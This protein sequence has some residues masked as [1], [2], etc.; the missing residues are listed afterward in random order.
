M[1]WTKASA[2]KLKHKP[3]HKRTRHHLAWAT[4]TFSDHRPFAFSFS[5]NGYFHYMA[6][7]LFVGLFEWWAAEPPCLSTQTRIATPGISAVGPRCIH[8]SAATA[9]V[10]KTGPAELNIVVCYLGRGALPLC[11]QWDLVFTAGHHL[12]QL[13][14]EACSRYRC[15]KKWKI[16]PR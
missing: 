15:K 14:N 16:N 1:P 12:G 9:E 6:S 4:S 10:W 8:D 3:N 5:P 7:S 13:I 11:Y 2:K